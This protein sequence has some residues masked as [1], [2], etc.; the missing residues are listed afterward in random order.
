MDDLDEIKTQFMALNDQVTAILKFTEALPYNY[1]AQ[2]IFHRAQECCLTG[3]FS[4][5]LRG[6]C[7]EA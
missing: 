6:R 2:K 3:R 1:S 5:P 7:I 4:S